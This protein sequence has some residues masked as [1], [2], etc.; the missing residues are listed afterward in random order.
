MPGCGSKYDNQDCL[1]TKSHYQSYKKVNFQPQTKRADYSNRLNDDMR[2]GTARST[3]SIIDKVNNKLDDG[4][5]YEIKS[6]RLNDDM[7][8]G[9]TRPSEKIVQKETEKTEKSQSINEQKANEQIEKGESFSKESKSSRVVDDARP[10]VAQPVEKKVVKTESKETNQT[11]VKTQPALNWHH[12]DCRA[13]PK[14][15]L[16]RD[17]FVNARGQRRV[18]NVEP[19]VVPHPWGPEVILGR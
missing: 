4:K 12:H 13:F 6:N 11:I 19:P 17:G 10:A 16:L 9:S 18:V 15:F 7:R 3:D 5:R 2:V 8:L 14:S 1:R